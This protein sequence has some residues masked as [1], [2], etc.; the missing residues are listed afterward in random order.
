MLHQVIWGVGPAA[1]DLCLTGEW[2]SA[3]E[4]FEATL[5]MSNGKDKPSQVCGQLMSMAADDAP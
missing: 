1:N 3:R 4:G 5:Q 2:G